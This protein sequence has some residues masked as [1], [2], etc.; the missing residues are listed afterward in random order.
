MHDSRPIY[1]PWRIYTKEEENDLIIA[2]LKRENDFNRRWN[3]SH[4]YE[5]RPTKRHPTNWRKDQ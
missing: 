3:E 5:G 4:G 2:S 1:G